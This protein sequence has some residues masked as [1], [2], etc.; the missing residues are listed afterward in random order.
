M[1]QKIAQ[2]ADSESR[3]Q[4]GYVF[5]CVTLVA[6][7]E[8]LV[9]TLQGNLSDADKEFAAPLAN[10]AD[11]QQSRRHLL[12]RGAERLR[13]E[14]EAILGAEVCAAAMAVEMTTGVVVQVFTT[15]SRVQVLLL[16]GDGLLDHAAGN[17]PEYT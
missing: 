4:W 1:A 5:Q 6:S 9:V 10:E 3:R 15:G 17:E 2:A 13:Q 8:I 14:I 16:A 11:V 7:G 12:S